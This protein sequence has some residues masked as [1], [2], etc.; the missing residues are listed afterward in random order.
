M[1]EE[2]ALEEALE[3]LKKAAPMLRRELGRRMRLR[4][5]P[6]LHFLPDVGLLHSLRVSEI[7]GELDLGDEPAPEEGSVEESESE[8]ATESESEDGTGERQ[9]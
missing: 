7:L 8:S 4:R 9:G 6:E 5:V 1:G 2:D 3:A